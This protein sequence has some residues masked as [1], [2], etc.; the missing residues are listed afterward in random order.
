MKKEI[1]MSNDRSKRFNPGSR[2]SDGPAHG[3]RGQKKTEWW[4]EKQGHHKKHGGQSANDGPP[5]RK[6][7]DEYEPRESREPRE[8][9]EFREP[10]EAGETGKPHGGRDG[11]ESPRRGDGRRAG[12]EFGRRDRGPRR[13]GDEQGKRHGFKKQGEVRRPGDFEGHR[14]DRDAHRFEKPRHVRPSLETAQEGGE[15]DSMWVVGRHEVIEL[16][17]ANRPIEAVVIADSAHGE[18]IREIREEA[19]RRKLKL[20]VIPVQAFRRRFGDDTQSVA[21]K[22]GA[23]EYAE[24]DALLDECEKDPEAVLVALNH[25]EDPRNLGAV[26]RTV[27]ASGASGIVIPRERAAAMTGGALRTAQGAASHLPV[28]KVV[29]LGVAIE[30]AKK[31][32]FWV[33]GLDGAAPKR[34]DEIRYT[35]R[36]MLVAG[37][38]DVGLGVRIGGAC[39]ECVSIPLSGK[40]PSLNVSVSTAVALFEVLRQKGFAVRGRREK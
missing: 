35:G 1:P 34:Y 37:G 4:S 3:A 2:R 24:F 6:K 20:Q 21:A 36:V 27:E 40:T 11:Y 30:A 25:V 29:N 7:R 23:F 14:G 17:R 33:I 9:R 15:D 13:E 31:R 5:Q 38:E 26:V 32:G 12:G 8:I 10:R 28:A 16:L 39:D 22:T 19:H 18:A